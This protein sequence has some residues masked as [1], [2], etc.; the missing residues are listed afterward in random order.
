[1]GRISLNKSQDTIKFEKFIQNSP[2]NS[3]SILI[4]KP[5]KPEF[6]K[7]NKNSL[8]EDILHSL[9]SLN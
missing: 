9:R 1:M 3:P 6:R 2:Y 7:R 4:D 5:S 8:N